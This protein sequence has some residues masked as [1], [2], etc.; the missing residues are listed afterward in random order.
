[1]SSTITIIITI[2][3]SAF[4]SGM[5]IA[6]ISANRMSLEMDKKQGTLTS[7]IL[8]IFSSNPQQYIAT[9]LVGNNISLV[10]YGLAF[11]QLLKPYLELYIQSDILTLFIQTV[12]STLLILLT[13]EFLPKT[14]FRHNANGF[15]NFLALPVLLFYIILYPIT[16][17]SMFLSKG[18]IRLFLK[19]EIAKDSDSKVFSKVD[20][21]HY[22]NQ[23]NNPSHSTLE[24]EENEIKLF[25]NALDFSN[26]RVR[27]CMLPRTEIV[28]VDEDTSIDDLK[29]NFIKSGYSKILIYRHSVD[30]M[31]GYVHSSQIFKNPQSLKSIV[32]A[33]SIVPETMA[34]SKL[35]SLF[36]QKRR[37]IAVVVDEFGG[38][39]GLVTTE[40]I[41]EEIFGEIEDEHDV[42][43]LTI[44]NIKENEWILSARYEI[45]F[46][47]EKYNFNL[48]EDDEYDTIAGFIIHEHENIPKI[49]TII[50]IENFEFR[51]LKATDMRIELVLM[52]IL[53]NI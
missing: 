12:I 13:A 7:G 4:F 11:A 53:P 38:T 20:L 17:V 28:A 34:A 44:K 37:T 23:L 43:E 40:D 48:P 26:V 21:D 39:S 27:D 47:N 35:L 42:D 33:I 3:F 22:I 15:L 18:I 52:K 30:N 5:E 2:V 19:H 36:T 41:L 49:N 16:K 24:D 9:M 29:Q 32:K 46:I 50:R 14:L 25:K 45:G 8:N 31:I 6:F 10:I 51:I 1:M